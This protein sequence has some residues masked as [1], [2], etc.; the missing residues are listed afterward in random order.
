M[1]KA[2]KGHGINEDKGCGYIKRGDGNRKDR[3]W[4]PGC[5]YP[6]R[7]RLR[8]TARLPR[9]SVYITRSVRVLCRQ[10]AISGALMRPPVQ[11]NR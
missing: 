1:S 9:A 5:E 7:S 11:A 3:K 10:C 6:R 4:A 2:K 8:A